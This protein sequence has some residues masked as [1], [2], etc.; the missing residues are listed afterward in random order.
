MATLATGRKTQ[1]VACL[2]TISGF[3]V[4]INLPLR[5]KNVAHILA[6]KKITET[7]I[8]LL[9]LCVTLV[10]LTVFGYRKTKI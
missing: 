5:L 8:S 7:F 4:N 10:H 9:L 2:S 6:I 1:I 3:P